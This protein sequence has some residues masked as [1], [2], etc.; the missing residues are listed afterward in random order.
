MIAVV[1][2]KTGAVAVEQLG[3]MVG[4][5]ASCWQPDKMLLSLKILKIIALPDKTLEF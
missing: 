4:W 5:L 1:V 2:W 3:L